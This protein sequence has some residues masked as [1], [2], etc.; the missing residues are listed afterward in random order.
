MFAGGKEVARRRKDRVTPGGHNGDPYAVLGESRLA[1]FE[2][3]RSIV[4][5]KSL[6]RL[7]AQ[8]PITDVASCDLT[9]SRMRASE[10][11]L[12]LQDGTTYPL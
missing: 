1:F 3:K 10:I 8:S 5:R 7:L 9:P 4:Q 12:G 6:G 11:N 2:M